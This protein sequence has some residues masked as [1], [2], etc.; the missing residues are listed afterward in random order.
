MIIADLLGAQAVC[1]AGYIIGARETHTKA[2]AMI[3]NFHG[4]LPIVEA[5]RRLREERRPRF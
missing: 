1:D 5:R 4:A 2:E 3:A